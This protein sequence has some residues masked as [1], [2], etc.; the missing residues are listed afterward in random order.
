MEMSMATEIVLR[1]PQLKAAPYPILA[2]LRREAP[3]CRGRG[4]TRMYW[5]VTRYDDVL[6]V[7]ND[8]RFAADRRNAPMP[9]AGVVEKLILRI[10]GPLLR[11]MLSSD[12]PDH[13]RLRALVQ[14]AFTMRRVEQLR[15]RVEELTNAY[16]DTAERQSEWDVVADYA[17]PLP[18]TIIS[19]M[20]GVPEAER[21]QFRRCSDT[22]V[23]SFGAS[24]PRM[25]RHA[26]TMVEF[27]SYIRKMVR[28]RRQKPQDDLISGL[29][30]AEESGDRLS[31]DELVSMILLLLVA[32]HETTVNLIGN[33]ILAL[34]ENSEQWDRLRANPALLPLAVEEFARYY[35]PVDFA[36]ARYTTCDVDIGGSRIL[37]GQA[38][39]ASLA[40]ANRDETK[41]E[42]PEILHVG[43]EPNRHVAFGH[44]MHHCLGILLARLEAQVAFATLLR[45]CP[46]L[47][48]ATPRGALRW[49]PSVLLRGLQSLPVSTSPRGNIASARSG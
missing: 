4:V 12:D 11:N 36:N 35:S 49:R 16:L 33:G 5:V 27:L 30:M 10:Y 3:V 46:E 34:L 9:A 28:L 17:L 23:Q 2:R 20:L 15:G 24:L 25:L 47:R 40:S 7:L 31:E 32:G 42:R 29:V 39:L 6:T 38:V 48:L 8:R 26:P 18:V 43:R 1:D 45:R 37:R 44:G 14:Q 41:F 22:L 21:E 13:A 19:E